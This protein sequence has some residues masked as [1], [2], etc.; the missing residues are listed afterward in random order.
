MSDPPWARMGNTR[1]ACGDGPPYHKSLPRTRGCRCCTAVS[2]AS[3]WTFR[4]GIDRG[5]SWR[6]SGPG[7]RMPRSWFSTTP[8]SLSWVSFFRAAERKRNRSPRLRTEQN[9][10]AVIPKDP[11]GLGIPEPLADFNP[12]MRVPR[13]GMTTDAHRGWFD[14]DFPGWGFDAH[15]RTFIGRAMPSGPRSHRSRSA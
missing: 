9:A 2:G 1:I 11:G 13:Q 4:Y 5:H 10:I 8:S 15:G 3:A 12:W 14:H 6:T 7:Q